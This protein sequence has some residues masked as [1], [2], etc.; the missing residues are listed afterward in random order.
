[1]RARRAVEPIYV[2][3]VEQLA[4]VLRGVIREGDVVLTLGAGSIGAVAQ[5]LPA[6]LATKAPVGVPR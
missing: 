2:E 6:A 1:M 3:Q 5:G 4:D